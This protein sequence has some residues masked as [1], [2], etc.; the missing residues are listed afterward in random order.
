MDL[1]ATVPGMPRAQGVV[2]NDPYTGSNGTT[3]DGG[4]A[5]MDTAG[6]RDRFAGFSLRVSAIR[7]RVSVSHA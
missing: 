3:A 6:F 5:T 2:L 4:G 1:D 7:R